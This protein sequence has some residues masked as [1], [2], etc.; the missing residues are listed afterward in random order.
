MFRI[1]ICSTWKYGTVVGCGAGEMG[2]GMRRTILQVKKWLLTGTVMLVSGS[3]LVAA[4]IHDA[5]QKGDLGGVLK[6]LATE[7]GQL[8]SLDIH[9]RTPLMVAASAGRLEL[10]EALL[11]KGADT[12]KMAPN[13]RSL[14]YRAAESGNVELLRLLVDKYRLPVDDVDV[15]QWAPVHVA[16]KL[17]HEAVMRCLLERRAK[18]NLQTIGGRTPLFVAVGEKHEAV[19]RLLLQYK[20][21][22]DLADK[23]G[24]T[25]LHLAVRQQ[26]KGLVEQLI[27][28]GAKP[29]IKARDG[30]TPAD[31]ARDG[32][33]PSIASLLKQA[34]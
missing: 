32:A 34:R 19:V 6:L 30:R 2:C 7:P 3:N 5:V 10:A 26:Q 28:A 29:T 25:P 13:K 14:V 12:R 24:L 17:G 9:G 22:P 4:P 23:A 16:A 27:K 11:A 18:L 20:A 15:D 1:L 33:D 8:D 21:K 31:D